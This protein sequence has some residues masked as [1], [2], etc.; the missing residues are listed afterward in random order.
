MVDQAITPRGKTRSWLRKL[1]IG[2]ACLALLILAFIGFLHTGQARRIV[3]SQVTRLLEQQNVSFNADQLTYNLFDLT[4]HMRNVRIAAEG[5]GLPPF[6][7]IDSADLDLS[8]T[9]LLRRRYVLQSGTVQGLRVHYYVA[10]DGR[11]NLPRP[12]RD[13]NEPSQP[14]NYL[15]DELG[16]RN[17]RVHYESRRD[18]VD[19]L[20]PVQSMEVDGN[21]LNDRHRITLQMTG[22]TAR[23]RQQHVP[24]DALVA[25][26]D[27]GKDDVAVTDAQLDV[28]RSRVAVSGNI[29]HF[30]APQADLSVRGQIDAAQA[31]VLAGVSEPIIGTVKLDVSAKGPI[32]TPALTAHIAGSSLGFRKIYGVDAT[33]TATYDVSAKRASFSELDLRA[34]FGRASG[35][36][37]IDLG[38]TGESSVRAKVSDLDTAAVMRGLDLEYIVLSSV[39]GQIDGR[40]PGLEYLKATGNAA[41][42][43]TATRSTASRSA[44]PVS[45][46]VNATGSAGAI[47]ARLSGVRAAGVE[48]SGRVALNDKQ[49]IRGV[50]DARVADAGRTLA[51]AGAFLGRREPLVPTPVAGGVLAVAQLG[52]TLRAP[53]VTAAVS[54]DALSV[55]AASGIGLNANLDYAPAAVDI[56]NLDVIWGRARAS[57]AG[58]VGLT[59]AGGL[60][61]HVT[62]DSLEVPEV[63]KAMNTSVPAEGAI[64]L[65]GTVGGTLSRPVADISVQGADLAAYNEQ[66]GSLV[67]NVTVA[68]REIVV[69]K[70]TLQKPQPDGVGRLEMSGRYDLDDRTYAFTVKSSD[71]QLV[72]LTLPDGETLLGRIDLAGDGAGTVESPAANVDVVAPNLVYGGRELGRIAIDAKV[73]NQQA[74]INTTADRFAL[75]AH[76]LVGVNAPYP[77]TLDLKVADLQLSA[78]PLDLHTP[79]DGQLRMSVTA[80]GDLSEPE[81]ARA[82]AL[83]DAFA[84]SWNGNPFSIDTPARMSYSDERLSIERLRLVARDSTLLVS[85]DLP[86]TERAGAGALNVDGHANVATLASYAP[87]GSNITGAG[88]LTLTGVVRGTMKA[89]DPDLVVTVTNGSLA[90]R[91][92]QPAVTNV[93]VRAAIADGVATIQQM[94]AQW[95]AARLNASGRIPLEVVPALPVDIPRKGGPATFTASVTDLDPGQIPG[96]PAGLTGRI[97]VGADISASRPTLEAIQGRIT[98]GQLAV[99]YNGLTLAQDAPSTIRL[100]S[101]TA[102]IDQLSLSGSLGKIAATGTVGLLSP[103]PVNVDVAGNLNVAVASLFTDVV[104]AEG[105]TRLQLALRGT[106]AAPEANGFVDLA[107]GSFVVDEPG[108]AAE[109]VA[110]RLDLSGRR[111]SLTSLTGALNGGQVKGS[112]FV[113]LGDA[114]IADIS[115]QVTADD[116]A[117]DAPLDLRSLS[118]GTIQV[119]K[120]GDDFIVNGQV[121]IDE[122]GLTGDINFDEGILAA[123]TARRQIDLTEERNAFLQRVRFNVNVDTASPI[124]VDNNLA[125]AEVTADLRITGTPYEP[126]LAGR[127]T[128][129][130]DSEI[131]LN[132]RRYA[133]ERGVLTF[134]DERRIYPQFDLRLTTTASNYDVTVA[135][136]GTPDDTETVLTSDPSLPEPD[137]MALLV[138]GRTLEEMRGKEFEVAQEQVLSYLSGRLGSRLGRGIEQATGLTEVRIEPQ[139]IANETDPTARLTLAQDLTDQFR[140]VYSTSLTDANDQIWVA[141][142]D[143]TRRF[144]SRAVRQSDNSY[145]MEIRHDLRFGGSP[146]PR[147]IP[148]TRP[149]VRTVTVNGN[150]AMSEADL[151]ELLHVDPGK[152]YDFFA[153]RRGAERISKRLQEAGWLQSRVRVLKQGDERSVDVRLEV[154]A[155]P[156]VDL[157][158]EGATPPKRVIEEVERQWNRGVF[159]TQRLDDSKERL[160]AWLMEDHYLQPKIDAELQEAGSGQRRVVFRINPGTRFTT[161]RLAFEGARGIDPKELDDIINEQKLEPQLFT[162]PTQVTELLRRYYREQGYLL[163][164]IANPV[165]EFEGPLARV[166]LNVQEGPRFVVRNV[167]ASGVT[168]LPPTSLTGELPVVPGDP[169]LPFAAENALDH[170]RDVYWRRGYNDVRPDYELVLDRESGHVDV[171]FKVDEGPQ[172]VIADIVVAGNKKTS[173]HLVRE[174]VELEAGKPLDLSLLAQSRRNLYDTGAFSIV[175]VTREPLPT[176]GAEQP[177]RLNVTVREVQPLQVRYGGSYDTERGLGGSLD[178]SDHN[179]LGKARVIGFSTRYDGEIREG[180]AYINQPALR[181]FPV[182]LTGAVYTFEDRHPPT[183]L[184]RRFNVARKGASIDGETELRD[185]YR[186]SYG[187]RYERARTRDPQPGGVLDELFTVAPLATTLSRETRDEILDATRGSFLSQAFEYSPSWLGAERAYVRY[188][189]QYFHYIP[190]QPVRRERFTNELIRPRFVFATG[191]RIGLAR[192]L[193]NALPTSERFFAGGSTTLRGFAQNAV[194]PIGADQLPTGGSA[195][196]LLNNEVRFPMFSIV[197]GVVFADIGNVFPR[198]GDFD[199]TG[200]RKSSGVGV[201]LRTSWFLVRGDYG[202]ILDRRSGEPRGRFYFSIG[203]A[204]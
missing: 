123:M 85:G 90:A 58:H 60:D 160:Q 165:Y 86:L 33:T 54:A 21:P 29:T 110:A 109:N 190:L 201:R 180:R 57:A 13:P 79:L 59:G 162:D 76:A 161:V 122:A 152:P 61:L 183:T 196:L 175:D 4:I 17:A 111:I 130:E 120:S 128:V 93:N 14:L 113:A 22:G 143:V 159:D 195:M 157:Q 132:E 42:T 77:T 105:D 25:T 197:D 74:T 200:L 99:E 148:R 31:A 87:A 118:D 68:G 43:L 146:E 20:L 142:Y 108:I 153:A 28:E 32:A 177:V 65:A 191:A 117:F 126:G 104:R 26:I 78:L 137:I 168:V 155:G 55:G 149:T 185:R 154:A 204:F 96:A 36:G 82:N 156:R 136:S 112:G 83:I 73:A 35:E 172:S 1:A 70:L 114:G 170:I 50:V 23:Y 192:G 37:T 169:F 41:V 163:A 62:A 72:S 7:E 67:A 189:G 179:T 164:H 40:W 150:A 181:Y 51:N 34:P 19:V 39:N 12:P 44:M 144:E 81:R 66:L 15:V 84:G 124:L 106:A 198:L 95:G 194:G 30:E 6:A 127:L 98:A 184:T 91:Q 107:N 125:K 71:L 10:A 119:T 140:L 103:Q 174:Q 11:D 188:L 52:G 193:G 75:N 129:L 187:Y 5:G 173:D 182:E 92:V 94:V 56:E 101:G 186:L 138:T 133:V 2:V 24:I 89:I 139:L 171:N 63:L 3:L 131:T 202:L 38:G 147:R 121:T 135:V 158:F 9:Q 48:I 199:F 102:A 53:T 115:L 167:T 166:V 80:L 116:V 46:R 69:P 16:I 49:R 151:R 8:L 18:D 27:A 176:A 64:S 97:S 88:E 145:R 134:I 141:E 45:G 100:A 178:V 203:Q 47:N